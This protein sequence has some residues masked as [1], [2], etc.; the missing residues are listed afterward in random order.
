MFN[1]NIYASECIT[2]RCSGRSQVIP[3]QALHVREI[4]LRS[5]RGQMLSEVQQ[6]EL[7]YGD[8]ESEDGQD[9]FSADMDKMER[10]DV[11]DYL[12]MRIREQ[13]AARAALSRAGKDAGKGTAAKDASAD[14]VQ[15]PENRAQ[16]V[17][18]EGSEPKEQD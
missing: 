4:L 16:N 11:V 13:A 14:K 18:Q 12:E 3:N 15:Q 17:P 5:A 1:V 9:L 2:K 7:Q 6:N 10:R 8:D